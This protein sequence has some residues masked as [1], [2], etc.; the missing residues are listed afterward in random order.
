MI[1]NLV[2]YDDQNPHIIRHEER[3]DDGELVAI[4]NGYQKDR[5]TSEHWQALLDDPSLVRFSDLPEG[6]EAAKAQVKALI[7]EKRDAV[8]NGVVQSGGASFDCDI[9]SKIRILATYSR[10]QK[11]GEGF[12]IDWITSDDLTHPLDFAGI[13]ALGEAVM[14]REGAA[15]HNAKAHKAAVDLLGDSVAIKGY[16]YSSG[17]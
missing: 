13:T 11:E 9:L 1:N 2:L 10:A 5:L 16:D 12:A 7:N 15:I 17:W 6:V 3:N 8:I 14:D 4:V